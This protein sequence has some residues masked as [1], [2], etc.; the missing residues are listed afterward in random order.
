MKALA[1]ARDK[2]LLGSILFLALLIGGGTTSGLYTDSLLEGSVLLIAAAVFWHSSDQAI[3]RRVLF[4]AVA[5]LAVIAIQLVPLPLA[6]LAPLRPDLLQQEDAPSSF[7]FISLGVGRTVESLLFVTA[8]LAFMLSLLRLRPEQ[9]HG[10]LPVFFTGMICN[11]LAGIIQ[12]SLASSI[13]VESFLPYTITGGLFANVNHFAALLFVSIPFIVY[14]AVSRGSWPSGVLGLGLVLLLLLA[15]GSRA[16]VLIGF[17]TTVLSLVFLL[18]RTRLSA[19]AILLMFLLVSV[20]S[21]GAWTHLGDGLSEPALGRAEIAATTMTGISGNWRIGV[22]FGSF[23]N[24]YQIYERQEMIF[25][26]Y[27]NHAH[28]DYLEI[29]FEGGILAA[30]VL[31]LYI[32]LLVGRMLEIRLGAFQKAA[33]LA[34]C[35]LLVHSLVDYPLRTFALALSFAYFNAILFH[36][37]FD[38]KQARPDAGPGPAGEDPSLLQNYPPV[39]GAIP[40]LPRPNDHIDLIDAMRPTL[41]ARGIGPEPRF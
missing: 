30:G 9:L 1:P 22:G 40:R 12:Y 39:I 26:D 37:G 29:V 32:A 14:Y 5:T 11:L 41:H 38:A 17:A 28:N 27:V 13:A 31:A 34:I 4:L 33:A 18:A 19:V 35:F 7:G 6:W 23:Q 16:G 10:L 20:F 36:A 8:T 15:A 2:Y 25:R 3:D 21:A 24:A